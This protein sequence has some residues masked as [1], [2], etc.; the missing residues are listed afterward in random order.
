MPYP[1][2]YL[3]WIIKHS[4]F[5]LLFLFDP[6]YSQLAKIKDLQ[7]KLNQLPAD[8]T[9]LHLLQKMADAYTPVDPAKKFYYASLFKQLAVKLHN[10]PAVADAYFQMGASYAFGTKLDSALYYFKL[11]YAQASKVK[12]I[13]GMGKGLSSMG[14][15]YDR[16]DDKK[17]AIQCDFQSLQVLKNTNNKRAINQL[18]I[19]IGSIYFDLRQYQLAQ[20]Y[21]EQCL[22]SY[23]AS[24][25]T[26]GI[27]YGL[28]LMGNTAQALRR[29]DK[30]LDYFARSL[31]IREKLEDANGI[32][33]VKRG[34]GQAYFHKKQYDLSVSYLNIALQ[35][36]KTLQNKYEE[37]AVLL[38]LS[39]V[40]LAMNQ[41]SKSIDCAKQSLISCQ[42]IKSKSGVSESLE[43]LIA[44][45][46]KQGDLANAFKYQTEYI[47]MQ[48]SL[49]NQNALKDVTLTEF[50]R[51]RT[52]NATLAKNNQIITTKNTNYL[53]QLNKYTNAIV[54]IVVILISVVLLLLILYRRNLEKQT[55]NK[56][57]LKQKEE[58][59]TINK[60]LE[61]LNEEIK[62]QMELTNAQNVELERLNSV[63]N[64]FFSIVSHD[65]RGPLVTLQMLFSVYR[66]GDIGEEDF[67]SLLT[68]LED[69]LLSTSS[70]LD[71]LLEWSKNQLEG[72]VIKPV[73]FDIGECIAGNIQ[74]F[75]SKIGMKK[76]KVYNQTINPLMVY[77]DKN[78]ITLVIRN[79]LSNSI[80]FCSAGDEITFKTE[81]R[82]D[83]VLIAIQDTGP[84]ISEADREN[85]FNLEHIISTGTQNEKGNHLGLILCKDMIT[86]NDGAIW[87]ET[88]QN[89]GTTFWIE[90]PAGK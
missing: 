63:K 46:K 51:I 24:K 90:L 60:E 30:A 27:G 6:C 71:N 74:L 2:A 75:E 14:F 29:D 82:N 23:T 16:L 15:I 17:Q 87:F 80:K 58:I 3:K 68:K 50:S 21:F 10:E 49:L 43:R 55:T 81:I 47:S 28:F 44:A 54:V 59:A 56:L 85:L 67:G 57:L 48:E 1:P 25:D 45:Y 7:L 33:L 53:A 32:A 72:M 22:I 31:A 20:S 88:I 36:V 9:R 77:A 35:S 40:Y 37:C 42:A 64:K 78:M 26:A 12:Y 66:E 73:N 19:N 62:A 4:Y 18:Y 69:T 70:F 84:G 8:T 52:E 86:Q 76:L 13:Y 41:Y 39:D 61:T 38:D 79:L 89:E 34:I 65:L 5:L 83:R 11:S